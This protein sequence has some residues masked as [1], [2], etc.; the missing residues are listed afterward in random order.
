MEE[1]SQRTAVRECDRI[2]G[3]ITWALAFRIPTV[4]GPGASIKRISAVTKVGLNFNKDR[5][6]F[7]DSLPPGD[8]IDRVSEFL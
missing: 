7:A 5:Q 8:A 6:P 4:S 2:G 3:A 1:I